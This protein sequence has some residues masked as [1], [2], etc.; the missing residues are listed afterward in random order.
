[1]GELIEFPLERRKTQI[2]NENVCVEWIAEPMEKCTDMIHVFD[3][4]PGRCKC[5]QNEW[6]PDHT[7][8]PE[9]SIGI[10]QVIFAPD[11]S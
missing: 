8:E 7:I 10:H 3:E 6:T 11:A 1:M 4:V 5:G 9:D 2:Q